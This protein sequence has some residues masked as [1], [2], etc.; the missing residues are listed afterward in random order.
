MAALFKALI[1]T[2]SV[3]IPS[4]T[5]PSSVVSFGSDFVPSSSDPTLSS[6]NDYIKFPLHPDNNQFMIEADTGL[7]SSP[8]RPVYLRME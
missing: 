1:P 3:I 4:V 6:V 8:L 2:D 7:G 5:A